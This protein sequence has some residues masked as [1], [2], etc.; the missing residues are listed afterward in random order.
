MSFD[1]ADSPKLATLPWFLSGIP[2]VTK[3]VAVQADLTP[4]T[5][6]AVPSPPQGQF[7][8]DERP[9]DYSLR[10]RQQRM[11]QNPFP[12][13]T[14]YA[15]GNTKLCIAHGGG[16]RCEAPGCTRSVQG[17]RSQHCISHGG[18]KRCEIPG[19]SRSARGRSNRCVH[20]GGGARCLASGCSKSAQRP[21]DYCISHGGGRRCMVPDCANNTRS[22]HPHLCLPHYSHQQQPTTQRQTLDSLPHHLPNII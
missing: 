6:D 11:C 19:C 4:S 8:L 21:S 17:A 22:Q 13:C 3:S 15:Q 14:R 18:G 1:P 5:T 16:R 20:H 10:R 9:E 2:L 7:S 12:K